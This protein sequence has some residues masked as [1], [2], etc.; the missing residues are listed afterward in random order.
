MSRYVRTPTSSRRLILRI[1]RDHLR[2]HMGAVGLAVFCM[3]VV[4]AATAIMAWLMQPVLDRIFLEKDRAMLTVVPLALVAVVLI[5][6]AA[7]YFQTVLMRRVGQRI[8]ADLQIALFDHLMHA[9]LTLFHDQ[10]AGR[11]ISRFTNDI[12]SMRVAVSTALT[13]TA[14]ELL[15]LIF[16]VGVMIYQ[17][18]ELSLIAGCLFPV[19]I[20]PLMRLSKRMRKIADG[21]Q[22]ELGEFTAQL[23]ETFTGVRVV[24][25]YRREDYEVSRARQTVENLFRLYMK[26]SRVQA[27]ASPM[28]EALGGIA[29]AAVIAYGGAQVVGGETTPGAFFSFMTAMMMVYRP[30]R[31][32]AGLNTNMQEGLAA[33]DRLFTVLDEPPEIRDVPGAVPLAVPQ[34]ALRF[35]NVS[36]SYDGTHPA[37]HNVTLEVPPGRMAALVGPSGSGKSTLMNL[38]LRFYDVSD[39]RI[40]IDGQEIRGVTL[41]TLRRSVGLVSQEIMLFDDTVAAN[42]AYGREGATE[43]DI[44]QAAQAAD[45]HGFI[46]ALPEGYDSRIGPSGVR[47]SGGQRQRIAIARAMLKNAP[48]LLLDEATSALDTQSERSVQK[49]LTE[50]MQH[51]T[52]LVIAHRLSTIRHADIIY[53]MEKGR[54]VEQGTHDALLARGGLYAS[55]YQTQF[56]E[57]AEEPAVPEGR[58]SVA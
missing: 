7:N 14:K 8:V 56:E 51:R 20:H 19:A 22:R 40:T 30:L 47:L 32:I 3:I 50:L 16:L 21:T 27:A 52:T 33:A 2:H 36:F 31:A 57:T 28:M 29:I 55:L 42:I 41:E 58:E 43:E 6:G 26:A 45:A 48:I 15:T 23:D 17:S 12:Q 11:I 53:V 46:M 39:G 4:A 54:V 44:R 38:L 13:G 1:V 25:A 35:E 5:G 34:G 9:D 10:A 49:A 18:W 37:L 24:K